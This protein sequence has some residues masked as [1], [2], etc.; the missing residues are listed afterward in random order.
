MARKPKFEYR[1]RSFDEVK[2]RAE[3]QGGNFDSIFKRDFPTWSPKEGMNNLRILPP[4]FE[5]HNHYGYSIFVHSYVGSDKSS[6]LCLKK[7]GMAKRCPIC[8]AEKQAREAGDKE[9]ADSL[10]ATERFIY[11]ILD[12]DGD[13]P[14]KPLLWSASWSMD[15]DFAALC[16][17]E[18]S[19]KVLA[20]DHPDEGFDISFTR[21]GTKLNTRYI[22]LRIDRES[23][24]I[25][26]N[27]KR[28]S[29]I[30]D[31]ITENPLDSVLQFYPA[32]HLQ[33]VITGTNKEKDED[34]DDDD[35][36]RKKRKRGD[37]DDDDDD[38]PQIR[39]GG[40]RRGPDDDDDDDD[41]EPAPKKKKKVVADDDDD[42]DEPPFRTTKKKAAVDDDDDDEPAPKKKRTR[43]VADDDDDDIPERVR[44]Q[45]VVAD[46]DDEPAPRKKRGAVVEDDDDDE[47]EPAPKKKKRVVADDDDD[48]EDEPAPRRARR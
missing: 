1:E 48:D 27:A 38:L 32:A 39:R 47:D 11:W 29:L 22:G 45:K 15:R 6:Y 30:L 12:R 26:T 19:G 46:D 33:E 43:I 23:S 10:K 5:D 2:K 9:D 13:D 35:T 7:M 3:R 24:P 31:Y 40:A 41:D 34:L 21:K 28:Q 42:D 25:S 16:I 44:R 36:P 17:D 4:T 18:K 37:D 8:D 14:K 20:I